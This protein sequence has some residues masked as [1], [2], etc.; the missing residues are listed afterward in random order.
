MNFFGSC[1]PPSSISPNLHAIRVNLAKYLANPGL[2][3][4][5]LSTGHETILHPDS[6]FWGTWNGVIQVR[7]AAETMCLPIGFSS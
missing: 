5:L 1:I 2:Q 4:D 7:G 6:G 3:T